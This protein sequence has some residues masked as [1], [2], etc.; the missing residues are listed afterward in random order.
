MKKSSIVASF[1]LL[2]LLVL[3]LYS[4]R[5]RMRLIRPAAE[6]QQLA[7]FLAKRSPSR[8][9]KL[10][11][12]EK[13]YLAVTGRPTTSMF[14]LPSGPPVYIFDDTGMLVDWSGDI[15]DDSNFVR[16]WPG[17]STAT[18]ITVEEAKQLV[19]VRRD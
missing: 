5:E 16:R 7:A 17:L 18:T 9:Q 2:C 11:Q 19:K 3:W 6:E 15:G 8:V 14:T 12:N 13:S 4:E 10:S 1:V